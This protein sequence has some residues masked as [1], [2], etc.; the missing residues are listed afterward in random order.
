MAKNVTKGQRPDF[1]G[2]L[3]Q[4]T[5]P[6]THP[7]KQPAARVAANR[8]PCCAAFKSFRR[9]FSVSVMDVPHRRA[10]VMVSSSAWTQAHKGGPRPERHHHQH[11][12]THTHTHRRG[13]GFSISGGLVPLASPPCH[14][15]HVTGPRVHW[16]TGVTVTVTVTVTVPVTVTV[17]VTVTVTVTVTVIVT[18]TVT[19]I[20]TVTVTV[21]VSPPVTLSRVASP[22]ARTPKPQMARFLLKTLAG[23]ALH[24]WG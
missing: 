10:T 23:H 22:P 3:R 20:V 19:V 13:P 11:T 7:P 2:R 14:T 9:A 16:P 21:T 15:S 8:F 17:M 12:H 4:S 1:R 18:V 24:E 5:R 6:P